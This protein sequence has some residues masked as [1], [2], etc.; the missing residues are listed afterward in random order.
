M[1]TPVRLIEAARE[2]RL[3]VEELRWFARRDPTFAPAT[4]VNGYALYDV[5]AIRAWEGN[6]LSTSRGNNVANAW[7]LIWMWKPSHPVDPAALDDAVDLV[8]AFE[9][10]FVENNES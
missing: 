8:C 9:A 7:E 2:L 4:A 5:E 3:P 1:K 6:E 10:P